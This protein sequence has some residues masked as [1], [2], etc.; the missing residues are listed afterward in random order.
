MRSLLVI[1]T[2]SWNQELSHKARETGERNIITKAELKQ[3]EDVFEFSNF[4]LSN[5]CWLVVEV[6]DGTQCNVCSS[7]CK[8]S[9]TFLLKL[10]RV[11]SKMEKSRS[12]KQKEKDNRCS[13]K[14]CGY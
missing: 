1:A 4:F 11:D 8:K 12:N 10:C 9:L 13:N 5:G 7:Y 14:V 3:T 6:K 2:F